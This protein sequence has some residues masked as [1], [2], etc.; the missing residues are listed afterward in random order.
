VY[1]LIVVV[2]E[3][4][5][6]FRISS[7]GLGRPPLDIRSL[8]LP[9]RVCAILGVGGLGLSVH[10]ASFK[11]GAAF[12]L[13]SLTFSKQTTFEDRN[14]RYPPAQGAEVY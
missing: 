6:I 4:R 5:S 9:A 13:I 1:I 7:L 11:I 14:H 2:H 8:P 10:D 12:P 3:V